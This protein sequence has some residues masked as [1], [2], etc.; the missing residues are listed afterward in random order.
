MTDEF[1]AHRRSVGEISY[2]D[3]GEGP[4]TVFVHGVFTNALLWRNCLRRLAGHRRCIAIDLP[5]HGH[6]PPVADASVDGLASAVR[7][8]LTALEL[9]DVHLVGNDTGGAVCQLV[10]AADPGRFASLVLTNCDT[11]GNFPPPLFRP[12]VHLARLGLLSLL[13]PLVKAPRVVRQA[14]RIGYQHPA[15]PEIISSFVGPVLGSPSGRRFMR[16][17]LS[18][19]DSRRLARINPALRECRIPVALIWGTGDPLFAPRWASWLKDLIPG[20]TDVVPIPG[21]RL[22]FV[23]DRADEFVTALRNHWN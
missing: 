10:Y 17:L 12:A 20:A 9:T 4:V 6:T 18:S 7:T 15:P 3:V 8:V 19:M 21:G 1:A 2:L 22:F 11:E 13:R 16:E 14:Y 23:D 5:G